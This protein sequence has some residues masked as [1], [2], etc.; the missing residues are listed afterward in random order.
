MHSSVL[1]SERAVAVNIE[2]MRAFV[3]MRRA[4]SNYAELKKRIDVL[5]ETTAGKLGEH[6]KHLATIFRAL[7]ELMAPPP[8]RRHPVGF[9]P[10]DEN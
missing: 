8:K 4:A 6:D 5:E 10:P 9:R 3:E 7:K 2:I 1:R